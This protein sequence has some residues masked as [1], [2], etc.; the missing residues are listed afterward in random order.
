[1]RLEH[2]FIVVVIV[3]PLMIVIARATMSADARTRAYYW[4]K[5]QWTAFWPFRRGLGLPTRVRPFL[6]PLVPVWVEV[7]PGM[8][9]LLD[10]NDLVSRV[11]METGVWEAAPRAIEE[12]LSSGATFVD[13]GA[14]I[15]YYSLKAAAAVGTAGRVVAI[16]PNPG[17]VEKLRKN[18]DAS[19]ATSITVVPCAC[20][21]CEA[22][23]DLF[24]GPA[25]NSGKGSISKAN[26]EEHGP[27]GVSHRVR[28]KAL[29]D[30][31]RDAG[32]SRVD[33]VKIDVEGAEL[34]VLK[35]A[36]ETLDRYA[37]ILFIE[38]E[39]E[40]LKPMNT[41]V[42]EVVE[43]LRSRGY[44]LVHQYDEANFEFRPARSAGDLPSAATVSQ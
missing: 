20:Y 41:S 5:R 28:G 8:R 42:A 19:G 17:T 2:P 10:P 34:L 35:G 7:E 29:D 31:V 23:L 33:V 38:L 44:T 15:G 18:I 9:M 16:E 25:S 32:L 39:D 11:I 22:T 43:F 40:L 12:C 24:A 14:H 4:I 1:M 27:V 30:I 26:S 3:I 6:E 37:P 13:I 21:D 36:R